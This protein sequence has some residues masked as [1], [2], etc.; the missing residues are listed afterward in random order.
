MFARPG[1][2]AFHGSTVL[3]GPKRRLADAGLPELRFHNLR[4]ATA[5]LLLAQEVPLTTVQEV[6]G[7]AHF[8]TTKDVHGHVADELIDGAADNMD[9]ALFVGDP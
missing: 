7:H 4:H 8:S 2:G 9:A 6:L 5:S 1:G 3:K